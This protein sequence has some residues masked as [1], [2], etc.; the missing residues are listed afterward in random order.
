MGLE[1][2]STTS[3][4]LPYNPKAQDWLTQDQEQSCKDAEI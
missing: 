3:N 2:N 4:L 1:Q